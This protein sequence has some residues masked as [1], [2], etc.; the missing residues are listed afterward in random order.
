V[1]TIISHEDQLQLFTL[2]SKKMNKDITCYAFG[3]NAMMFY[4]YKGETKDIDLLFEKEDERK[5]FIRAIKLLG[6]KEHSP[7]KIYIEEKLRDKHRPLMFK[8][9]DGRFD[10]FVKKI[11]KTLL[12]PRMKEDTFAL[13]E[14]KGTHT[15]TVNVLRKEHLVMLKTVTERQNDFDDIKTIVTKEKNFDW[16]YLMDEVIWQY[17]H[18]DT[19]IVLDTE[20]MLKELQQYV[21]I[22]EKYMKQLY[23]V[24]KE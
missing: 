3:G 8:R 18:G 9:G 24:K 2:I 15:I 11:F 20:K 13:H 1:I 14:F 19:W 12:S 5:E 6:Y 4:G 16:Q 23:D 10:L 21:F 17:Q 7:M 22:G